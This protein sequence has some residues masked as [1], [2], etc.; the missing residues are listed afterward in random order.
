MAPPGLLEWLVGVT[1]PTAAREE[2]LGDL[3]EMSG[4][5]GPYLIEAARTVPLV[6]L[7]RIR[8]TADPQLVLMQAFLLYL[9]FVAPAWVLN[10]DFL[11][12]PLALVELAI[13]AA[14]ALLVLLLADAYADPKKRSPLRPLLFS[15]VASLCAVVSQAVL[16]AG[17]P[18]YALPRPIVLAGGL[19]CVLLIPALRLLFPAPGDLPQ[20]AGPAFRRDDRA[21]GL[22][23]ISPWLLDLAA[24]IA[25]IAAL[26]AVSRL[27]TR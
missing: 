15:A 19:L 6:I 3:R 26:F 25:V 11:F 14:I 21:R 27:G 7:S 1:I 4:E 20:G 23:R 22:P 24:S 8:R 18:R 17:D 9:A 13:P 16:A 2:V 5:L 12:G 10:H